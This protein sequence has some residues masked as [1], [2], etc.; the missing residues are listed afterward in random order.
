M[1][2]P[3]CR[4]TFVCNAPGIGQHPAIWMKTYQ[5]LCKDAI[6][7]LP[8]YEPGKPIELVAREYG[9]DPERVD[10]LAS[11]E[12]P[13]G[14]SPMAL[15]A[16]RR[17]AAETWLYPENSCYWLRHKLADRL[18]VGPD[19]LIFGAGSNEVF[20]LLADVFVAAGVEVV[21]GES[22]FISYKISTL[23]HGGTP[24]EV[25]LRELRHNLDA[26][27]GAVTERTRLVYLPNPNNPTG[28]ANAADEVIAFVR[29][30]PEH[31]V[32]C[33]DEAYA[34]YQEAAPDLR[35]LIAEGRQL[36]CT[37]T[38]SKIYGLAGL[39]IGYGYG[40]P[41]LVA[42]LERA[43]PPFN[44]GN[45]AQAAALAA[46]DDTGFVERSRRGNIEGMRYLAAGLERLGFTSVPSCGN[47][48]LVDFGAKA[49]D[50]FET[51]LQNGIIVRPVAGYDLPQYLRI[52]VGRPEQH[53][54]LLGV[55]E[56]SALP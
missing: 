34:E 21:M 35:P 25:P 47:F 31:V 33:Y 28:T 26:M 39:R 27:R 42:L 10:K 8:V 14:P 23:L 2:P 7:S 44:V 18:N 12:N 46:L 29:S 9:L 38:F 51:L 56:R 54:R 32:C 3:H 37:R 45:V 1:E 50:V 4:R 13:L 17:A 48:I 5:H 41:A 20:Y 24:V 55:L 11:N 36:I 53:D 43:R 30:L 16:A 22:A 49:Q 15:A 6:R 19:Q 52:T 40:C